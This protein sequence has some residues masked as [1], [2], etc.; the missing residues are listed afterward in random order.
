[1][2]KSFTPVCEFLGEKIMDISSTPGGPTRK[3]EGEV[4]P[5]NPDPRLSADLPAILIF[6][7]SMSCE[8][9]LRIQT[10]IQ[11]QMYDLPRDLLRFFFS[12]LPDNTCYCI[13]NILAP[14]SRTQFPVKSQTTRSGLM[15]TIKQKLHKNQREESIREKQ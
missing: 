3:A 4:F 10:Q 15:Q 1:M 9:H 2:N 14:F 8:I 12:Y 13:T 6:L 11:I 7:A 5:Y